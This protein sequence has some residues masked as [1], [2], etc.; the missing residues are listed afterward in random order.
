MAKTT[1]ARRVTCVGLL[2]LGG[3]CVGTAFHPETSARAWEGDTPPRQAFLAGSERA[4]PI[5]QDISKTLKQIDARLE[6]I[7]KAAAQATSH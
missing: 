6:K 4:L 7:E 3:Y 2:L 1:M 5:L